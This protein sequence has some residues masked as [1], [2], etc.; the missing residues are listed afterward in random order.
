MIKKKDDGS[1]DDGEKVER[2]KMKRNTELMVKSKD[3][4]WERQQ[5]TVKTGP[6]PTLSHGQ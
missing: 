4:K 3:E 1:G 5:T 2:V 6:K